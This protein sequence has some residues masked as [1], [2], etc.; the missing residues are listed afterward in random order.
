[1][2]AVFCGIVGLVVGYYFRQYV[3]RNGSP[4]KNLLYW[5]RHRKALKKWNTDVPFIT[6]QIGDSDDRAWKWSQ[7]VWQEI[8]MWCKLGEQVSQDDFD[9]IA[10]RRG[11][12]GAMRE[13]LH[14]M[15]C[16]VG[17]GKKL[18]LGG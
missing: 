1:M 4:V 17:L 9:F 3:E 15:M 2:L 16:H 18:S 8:W 10:D 6:K 11:F 12:D 14:D 5:Y 7:L 13:Y